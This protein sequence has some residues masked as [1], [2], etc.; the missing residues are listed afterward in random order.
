MTL[1]E[2]RKKLEAS[3]LLSP[4]IPWLLPA[5][6]FAVGTVLGGIFS[7]EGK[8]DFGLIMIGLPFSVIFG[9]FVRDKVSAILK[10]GALLFLLVGL[11][12]GLIAS[13]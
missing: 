10:G 4:G 9:F 1:S 13:S 7:S 6:G 3:G 11:A 5:I 12:L 2:D 8:V